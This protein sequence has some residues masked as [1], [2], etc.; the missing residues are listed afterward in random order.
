MICE[1]VSWNGEP[2]RCPKAEN[3]LFVMTTTYSEQP[4]THLDDRLH[5]GPVDVLEIANK[6][7]ELDVIAFTIAI[8]F[9]YLGLVGFGIFAA[10]KVPGYRGLLAGGFFGFLGVALGNRAV[11]TVLNRKKWNQDNRPKILL[12][13]DAICDHRTGTMIRFIDAESVFFDQR[14]MKRN[15]YRATLRLKMKDGTE[16]LFDL[17]ELELPSAEI[18]NLAFEKS[19]LDK[20]EDIT[21]TNPKQDLMLGIC[22]VVMVGLLILRVVL[23]LFGV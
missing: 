21:S 13:N 4:E 23:D 20:A 19:G 10:Y 8:A 7:N 3:L 17:K 14:Y 5:G 16:Q 6:K 11:D 1:F 15:E 18:A 12:S 9:C 2:V 22:A